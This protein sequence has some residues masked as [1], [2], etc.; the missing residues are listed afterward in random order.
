MS[1]DTAIELHAAIY[2][3]GKKV[4][5]RRG[6]VVAFKED[7][8]TLPV[9]KEFMKNW[10]EIPTLKEVSSG[11]DGKD[12]GKEGATGHL[13]FADLL[14]GL[15]DSD[16]TSPSNPSGSE[17]KEAESKEEP[18]SAVVASLRKEVKDLTERLEATTTIYGRREDPDEE[19]KELLNG[20][21]FN[22]GVL[23]SKQERKRLLRPYPNFVGLPTAVTDLDGTDFFN[24]LS[25]DNKTWVNT[26]VPGWEKKLAD[27]FRLVCGIRYHVRQGELTS[28]DAFQSQLESVQDFIVDLGTRMVEQCRNTVLDEVGVPHLKSRLTDIPE[29]GSLFSAE[30]LYTICD[31]REVL[32]SMARPF[33]RNGGGQA[34]GHPRLSR[35]E[36]ARRWG[37]RGRGGARGGR[38]GRGR[39]GGRGGRSGFS[40]GR[41]DR[42]S[43]SGS[44]SGH[45]GSGAPP[46]GSVSSRGGSNV[47][48][49]D[50]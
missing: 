35:R 28:A 43:S 37:R 11:S 30:D 24:Y 14:K 31:A 45:P 1:R 5:T 34:R 26:V 9:L 48:R 27:I 23:L 4:S 50:Q 17:D 18:W 39:G 22:R 20:A 33:S 2:P 49:G 29:H 13:S 38:G 32:Q 19:Q 10:K 12:E 6:A 42:S 16:S 36:R 7:Y 47:G 25:K 8:D 15:S 40:D 21:T 46:R 3:E 41:T 44:R